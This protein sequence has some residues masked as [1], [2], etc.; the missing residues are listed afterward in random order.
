M[1]QIVCFC[2]VALCIKTESL[3]LSTPS[4]LLKRSMI[5]ILT[6]VSMGVQVNLPPTPRTSHTSHIYAWADSTGKM[7]TKLTARRRYLPRIEKG[8]AEWKTSQGR[9]TDE[10]M[11][12]LVRAMGLYGASLRKGE[13]PDEISR[14]ADELT[15]EFEKEARKFSKTPSKEQYEVTLKSL[16]N[17]LKFAGLD[18]VDKY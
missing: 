4:Y 16:D 1:I 9:F 10:Q 14:Q 12:S 13:I 17:Y 7:S 5:A 15:Q 11:G 18:S 8:V 3:R 6:G 2:L